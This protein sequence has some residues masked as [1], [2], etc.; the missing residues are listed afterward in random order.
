M[1][2]HITRLAPSPTGA[3]HL[4][5]ARTFL[6]NWLLARQAGWR[7]DFRMEDLDTPRTKAG[8]DRQAIDDLAWLGLDWDGPV[9]YQST[10]DDAHRRALQTLIDAGVVFPCICSRKDVLAAASAPQEGDPHDHQVTYPGT[11]RGRFASA[12]DARR[13]AGR[14]PA[15][16]V[17]VDN[18]PICFDD[19][20]AGPQ[21]VELSRTCG[22][23]VIYRNEGLI[24]YQLAVIVD[25]H[26]AGVDCIVRGDDLLDSTARQIH[27]R[28]LLGYNDDE[29]YWHVP[30]VRGPDGLRLAK[31]HGDTR[32]SMYRQGNTTRQRML[33]LLAWWCGQID[34]RE[35]I[36]LAELRASFNIT[37]LPKGDITFTAE[38]DAWLRGGSKC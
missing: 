5:N 19:E 33:G 28:R 2:E 26:D 7:V 35:E 30:L 17:R 1:A 12:D 21:C 38:D 18:A 27:L 34:R 16:R 20:F 14:Q 24:G 37:R 32:I 8:A 3:L 6:L 13:T 10:R 4:G 31:R 23:F 36:S 15:W 29:R 25:D 9:L 22:D 11:C